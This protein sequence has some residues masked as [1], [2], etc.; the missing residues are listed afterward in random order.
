MRQRPQAALLS[1]A[2]IHRSLRLGWLEKLDI[3]L[4]K[5]QLDLDQRQRHDRVQQHLKKNPLAPDHPAFLAVQELDAA[6]FHKCYLPSQ[7]RLLPYLISVL[8]PIDFQSTVFLLADYAPKTS[9]KAHLLKELL[10]MQDFNTVKNYV[11]YVPEATSLFATKQGRAC[12]SLLAPAGECLI[13]TIRSYYLYSQSQ[14]NCGAKQVHA[15][16]H[17]QTFP[18]KTQKLLQ[19]R[20]LLLKKTV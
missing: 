16:L 4:H 15:L 5:N 10:E 3:A 19:K 8:H 18:I 9:G 7:R 6:L 11:R 20:S 13:Q 2:K 17:G 14:G 12:L 1:M